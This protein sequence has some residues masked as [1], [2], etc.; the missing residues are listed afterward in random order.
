[1]PKDSFERPPSS[2]AERFNL[3]DGADGVPNVWQPV[4]EAISA[5]NAKIWLSAATANGEYMDFLKR[6]AKADLAFTQALADCKCPAD[7]WRTY[8][9]FWTNA[10]SDYRREFGQLTSQWN[11]VT[12][13]SAAALAACAGGQR[14]RVGQQL[15]A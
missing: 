5:W 9:D 10:A 14:E 2:E 7:V 8:S 3:Q 6:R 1:M 12:A 4:V 15:A 13:E 11:A